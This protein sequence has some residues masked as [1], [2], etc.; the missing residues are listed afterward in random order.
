MLQKWLFPIAQIQQVFVFVE[1]SKYVRCKIYSSITSNAISC[2]FLPFVALST[3]LF[4]YQLKSYVNLQ[5]EFITLDS[6]NYFILIVCCDITYLKRLKCFK[7]F[8]FVLAGKWDR[9][10]FRFNSYRSRNCFY[11]SLF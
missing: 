4:A 8:N 2:V 9:I 7:N 10:F 1:T 5:I 11:C 3:C 6:I